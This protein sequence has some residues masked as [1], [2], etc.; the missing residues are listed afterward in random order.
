MHGRQAGHKRPGELEKVSDLHEVFLPF[1]CHY[2]QHGKHSQHETAGRP[3]QQP[4]L[5]LHNT[6]VKVAIAP[7]EHKKWKHNE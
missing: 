4:T 7:S 6:R 1:P 5:E 3:T 2:W